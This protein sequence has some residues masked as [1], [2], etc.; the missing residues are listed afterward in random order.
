MQ[1]ARGEVKGFKGDEEAQ[2]CLERLHR[3]A[4]AGPRYFLPSN[5]EIEAIWV[6]SSTILSHMLFFL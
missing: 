2:R 5:D 6:I 4:K 1:V 3:V